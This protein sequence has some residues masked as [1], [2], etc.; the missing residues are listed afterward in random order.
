MDKTKVKNINDKKKKD[1]KDIPDVTFSWLKSKVFISILSIIIGL[2]IGLIVAASLGASVGGIFIEFYKYNFSNLA[3]VG[4]LLGYTS[5]LLLLGLALIVSFRAGV[6]NI[7]AAGQLL[8]GGLA[9]YMTGTVLNV[10]GIGPLFMIVISA[11]VGSLVALFIGLLKTKFKVHEVV[12]SIM[13]NWII[14]YIWTHFNPESLTF[15][16]SNSLRVDWLTNLFGGSDLINI[17]IFVI[18]LIPLF[19]FLYRYTTFG[20][21]QDIIGSN[22]EAADYIGVNKDNELLKT[23]AISGALA[24]L[25]GAL[26]FTGAENPPFQSVKGEIPGSYFNGITIALLASNSPISALFASFFVGLF[27]NAALAI[28]GVASGVPITDI[29]MVSIIFVIAISNIFIISDPLLKLRVWLNTD[30]ELKSK[31]HKKKEK[32]SVN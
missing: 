13:I 17:G 23:F 12:S 27:E 3:G 7:G 10:G 18:L 2:V 19:W 21:K 20:Y 24:G 4:N 29:I 6:F 9:A 16:A 31:K 11:A 5:W 26:I 30:D 25:A 22:P 28:N 32:E 1:D 14:F 8:A 15:I